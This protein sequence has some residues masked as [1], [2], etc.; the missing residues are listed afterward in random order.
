MKKAI[1][2]ILVMVLSFSLAGGHQVTAANDDSLLTFSE[3]NFNLIVK[4]GEKTY[5]KLPVRTKGDY[6]LDPVPSIEAGADSPFTFSKP[7]MISE[8][9]V[10]VVMMTDNITAYIEFEVTTKETAGIKSYPVNLRIKGTSSFTQESVDTVLPFELKILEEKAPSQLTVGKIEN[11]SVMSGKKALLS[12]VVKNEGE[13]KA[14][15]AFMSIDYGDSGIIRDYSAVDRKIGDLGPGEEVKISL[16]VNVSP[17]ATSG[18]KTLT[19]KFSYKDVDGSVFEASYDFAIN[20]LE[21]ENIPSVDIK[22]IDRSKVLKP[23]EE[24]DLNLSMIN[25][26]ENPAQDVRV[27][28]DGTDSNFIKNYLSDYISA[29]SIR[30]NGSKD[31]KVPL[32][33]SRNAAN[34][35]NSLKL[36][37]QYTDSTGIVY[38]KE[39]TIYIEVAAEENKGVNIIVSNVK[40]S[41]ER[42]AA[43]GKLEVSFDIENKSAVDLNE[44]KLELKNL[45]GNTFIPVS[46]DPYQYIGVIK[47]GATKRVTVSLNVSENIPEGLNT[48][49][50]A[51]SYIGGSD[52]V[53]IPVRNVENDTL[54][55]TSKP[56]L[57]VSNYDTDVEQL[58]AGDVFNLAFEIRNTHSS[59]AAKNIIISIS[60]K[61]PG[62]QEVFSVTQGSNNFFV[63]K[64]GAGE[65]FSGTLEMKVKSDTATNAYPI[66]VNIEY[67]YDGIEPNPTTGEIGEKEQHELNLQ[68]AENARPV[69][70]YVQVY[71][72]DGGV[73]VNSPATLAFEFYNMGKSMLNNVIATVEGDFIN[74]SGNMY[75]MGNVNAGDRSYAEFEV[76]PTVE[77]MAR[78]TVR[79]TYED[80]NGDEQVYTKEFETNVMGE[81]TWNPDVDGG[82]DV[83]NP[84]TAQ[85]SKKP[86]LKTWIFVVIQVVIFIAFIPITRK[87]IISVYK[88]KLRKKEENMM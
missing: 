63:N 81:Q 18:K 59:V 15:N 70:D 60:G 16:P 76:L 80:S 74:S 58:K 85:E 84:D 9:N 78:G 79:I 39:K 33:V 20:V 72:W 29:N 73:I 25:S 62:G 36:T 69:V 83:F 61:A 55:G 75:F 48:L 44:F 30:G 88:N 13:I 27:S 40:Q 3:D 32:V 1:V 4:P 19:A 23:G 56:R 22:E 14:R 12:F 77:G 11:D 65:T 34:G 24:F 54:D 5:I 2:W 45:T 38:T 67:E 87:I 66:F 26:G 8:Y 68:V 57:I 53:E 10:P 49:S 37:I 71:S 50:V 6:I 52:S 28:I 43:G 41:P 35:F 86:I 7:T 42:P 31:V 17:A 51:Y 82:I 21:N 64:I 46:S 47:A